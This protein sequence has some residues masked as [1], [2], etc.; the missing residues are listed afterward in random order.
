MAVE[1]EFHNTVVQMFTKYMVHI[2][3]VKNK[4]WKS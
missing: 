3:F 1:Y 4:L 2:I